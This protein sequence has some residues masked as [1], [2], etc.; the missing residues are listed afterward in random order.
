MRF[1]PVVAEAIGIIVS[2]WLFVIII[3]NLGV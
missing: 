2:V 1:I 3:F